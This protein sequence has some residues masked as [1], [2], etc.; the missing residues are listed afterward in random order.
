M[1]RDMVFYVLALFLLLIFFIDEVVDWWEAL[2]LFCLYI[3]YGVFMKYNTLIERGIKRRLA[4]LTA[5][6]SMDR[7]VLVEVR[8]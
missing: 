6:V 5:S 1:F 4:M 2:I 8:T 3:V 7:K